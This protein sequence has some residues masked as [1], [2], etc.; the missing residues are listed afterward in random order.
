MKKLTLFLFMLIVAIAFGQQA[1][2]QQKRYA[3]GE[4]TAV[5]LTSATAIAINPAHTQT[6]YTLAADT[7]VTFTIG[8][9]AK[10]IIGDM[11]ILRLKANTRNRTFTFSGSIVGT[12]D[13]LS[14]GK[15]KLY[16]FLFTGSKY[17]QLSEVQID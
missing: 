4:R 9:G 14:T 13:T 8:S 15:S 1:I 3:F 17:E 7:N 2:A 5:T 6:I 12:A 11:V 10:S 16:L